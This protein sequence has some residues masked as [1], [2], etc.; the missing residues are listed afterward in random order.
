M[1]G[2]CIGCFNSNQYELPNNNEICQNCSR[3]YSDKWRNKEDKNYITL[4]RLVTE[5][6]N[7]LNIK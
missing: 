3:F 5:I 2:K 1:E 7:K 4:D 6:E